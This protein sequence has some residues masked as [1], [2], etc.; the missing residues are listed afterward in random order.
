MFKPANWVVPK[1][2]DIANDIS[3]ITPPLLDK[4]P[5]ATMNDIMNLGS[6][7]YEDIRI[8]NKGACLNYN[9]LGVCNDKSCTYRHSK[10]NPTEDRVK[11][12]ASKLGPAIQVFMADG[13]RATKKRKTGSS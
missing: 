12:V 2:A 1:N 4:F 5:K 9:M 10:A 6:L 11:A 13:G 7:R 3:A 8:G